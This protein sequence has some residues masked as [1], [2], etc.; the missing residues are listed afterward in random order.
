MILQY[1][2]MIQYSM[3]SDN[4]CENYHKSYRVE[5]WLVP[6]AEPVDFVLLAVAVVYEGAGHDDGPVP[7]EHDAL[8]GVVVAVVVGLSAERLGRLLQA[9]GRLVLESHP[10]L[11]KK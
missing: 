8:H 1:R 7:V 4:A 5:P 3:L 11:K 10:R 2:Y 9:V 6:S